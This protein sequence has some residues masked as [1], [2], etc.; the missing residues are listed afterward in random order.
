MREAT[1]SWPMPGTA[2]TTD[3]LAAFAFRRTPDVAAPA[4]SVTE[5]A[6]PDILSPTEDAALD[7]PAA[8]EIA[9]ARALDISQ[10]ALPGRSLRPVLVACD[11]RRT[12]LALPMCI[13]P[14]S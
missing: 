6:V 1:E 3:C 13:P 9:G 12:G 4:V 2:S 7:T 11:T 10:A 14:T 5:D 8:V